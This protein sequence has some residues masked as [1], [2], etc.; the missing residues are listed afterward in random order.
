MR[1]TALLLTLLAAGCST[2]PKKLFV[3]PEK[4]NCDLLITTKWDG[5]H[6]VIYF[7]CEILLGATEYDYMGTA[8]TLI[9][10]DV[11]DVYVLRVRV[12]RP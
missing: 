4:Y 8:Y 1:T 11:P 3:H 9:E 2:A 7:E 12:E 5:N 10:T 6:P